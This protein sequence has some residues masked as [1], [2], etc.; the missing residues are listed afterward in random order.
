MSEYRKKERNRV[1]R[2]IKESE[3]SKVLKK[4]IAC[5]SS[6]EIFISRVVDDIQY[7]TEEHAFRRL[8]LSD[9]QL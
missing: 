7:K 4:N 5:R 8:D 3:T 2:E 9:S 1:K 6:N